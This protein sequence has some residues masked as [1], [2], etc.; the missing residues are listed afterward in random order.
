M[1]SGF[2]KKEAKEII[3]TPIVQQT[4]FWS[5][6]KRMQGI[7]PLA[8]DFK[9]E[10]SETHIENFGEKYINAD[11][12]LFQQN[13]GDKKSIAYVPYGPEIE[14][15]GENKG[16]F[17]EELSEILRGHLPKECILIRY[18]LYWKS[19]WTDTDDSFDENGEWIGPPD[20]EIQEL[21]FNYCTNYWNL[22][23]S[24][25]DI[26]PSNT[27]YVDLT[28]E[29]EIILKRMKPKTRY[30]IRLSEKKGVSVYRADLDKI[31]LWYELYKQTAIRNNIRL[32]H[33]D[34]FKSVLKAKAADAEVMLLIAEK[35][36][37][38]LAAMFLII[39]GKRATYLYGASSSQVR[40]N[41]A[42]YAI[43]WKAIKIAKEKECFDYDM[44]G[45][46]PKSDPTHPLSGLYRFKS[47]FGGS[48]F[49]RMGCWDYPLNNE[50][51]NYY[52]AMEIQNPTFHN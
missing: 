15:A 7:E 33:I 40:N 49:H 48:Q 45:I 24:N 42:T 25:T 35:E 2:L 18:D 8:Y 29:K 6:V 19:F 52:T 30:N 27:I 34:Y 44:F 16:A 31:A 46:A 36:G 37:T 22:K 41:M 12:L 39:T 28:P 9:L 3:E 10:T 26:L 4:A 47:G 11:V 50:I 13:V 17:L 20:K 21:R 32:H 51:Y 43:Q 1:I 23:K 14:P 5:E 38:P